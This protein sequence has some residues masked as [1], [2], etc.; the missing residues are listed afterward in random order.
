MVEQRGRRPPDDAASSH[1]HVVQH[2]SSGLLRQRIKPAN[3][4]QGEFKRTAQLGGR[5]WSFYKRG[6]GGGQ[7]LLG[8]RDVI[9]MLYLIL[10]KKK[11]H[12]SQVQDVLITNHGV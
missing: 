1:E 9:R 4:R 12:N 2:G 6:R 7:N 3:T 5:S 10:C 11:L 8:R